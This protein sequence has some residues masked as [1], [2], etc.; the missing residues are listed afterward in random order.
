MHPVGQILPKQ[1]TSA[2]LYDSNLFLH[3]DA[4]DSGSYPGSGS[5]WYDLTANSFDFTLGNVSYDSTYGALIF[6]GTNSYAQRN[7]QI[8]TLFDFR[9][10]TTGDFSVEFWVYLDDKTNTNDYFACL[11]FGNGTVS[12][13]YWQWRVLHYYNSGTYDSWIGCTIIKANNVWD[14]WMLAE[15][16]SG[17]GSYTSSHSATTWYQFVFTYDISTNTFVAYQNGYDVGGYYQHNDGVNSY[18]T[19][20]TAWDDMGIGSA[21]PNAG[22]YLSL[23][24][25]LAIVRFYDECIP[26][27]AVEGNW[28]YNKSRFGY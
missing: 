16:P 19:P 17:G 13:T 8:N 3:L 26:A 5:T 23:D 10:L 14:T 27:S 11:G 15:G 22:N 9:N 28:N 7:N 1:V 21:D 25:R 24:G 2:S 20:N 4:G 12:T 18:R 6:S